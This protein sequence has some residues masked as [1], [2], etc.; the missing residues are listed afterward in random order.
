MEALATVLIA[1]GNPGK[2]RELSRML[3]GIHWL[4]LRDVAPVELPEPGEDY[5]TNATAKALAASHATGFV[6]LADDSGLDVDALGGA[7][8]WR[9]A[10]YAG[11]HGDDRANR[12]RLLAAMARVPPSARRARFRCVVA[13]ADARGPLGDRVLLSYGECEGAVAFCE[14]GTGGFGY[15]PIFEVAGLGV[16]MAELDETTK[17]RI[18]HRGRA[19][20][21]MLPTLRAYLAAR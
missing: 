8:G 10:R 12:A 21:A 9:S 20:A 6:T 17:N 13:V 15:D 3:P 18:S 5:A 19:V 11:A 14:R 2:V 16:T 7:P 1:S 4:T